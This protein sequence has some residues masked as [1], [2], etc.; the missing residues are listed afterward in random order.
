[1]QGIN[2]NMNN[3]LKELQFK[4]NRYFLLSSYYEESC[5]SI[6]PDGGLVDAYLDMKNNKNKPGYGKLSCTF[7][8][9]FEEYIRK[10][11][12]DPRTV[13]FWY[14]YDYLYPKYS[15]TPTAYEGPCGHCGSFSF[16]ET[17]FDEDKMLKYIMPIYTGNNVFSKN[18]EKLYNVFIC[19][20]ISSDKTYRLNPYYCTSTCSGEGMACKNKTTKFRD[21]RDA[22][23]AFY[24]QHKEFTKIRFEDLGDY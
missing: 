16:S 11:T 18:G 9:L 15:I 5:K 6:F 3:V 8:N 2:N 22:D 19:E 23:E 1:M 21:N 17:Y 24:N 14:K 20:K 7:W 10:S 13:I 12:V 4:I